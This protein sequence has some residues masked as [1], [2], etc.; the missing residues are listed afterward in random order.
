MKT[1]KILIFLGHP[2]KETL[3]GAMASA[4]ERGAR[5][6]GHEVKRIN[7]GDLVFDPILHKGYKA[8][9]EL[10]PDLKRVQEE[11]RWCDHFVLFYPNWFISMPALLKGMFERMWLPGFAYR[12]KKNGMGWEKLLKGRTACVYITM[13][14]IP[15]MERLLLGDFTNE[16]QY[17]LLGFAGFDTKVHKFGPVEKISPVKADRLFKACERFGAHAH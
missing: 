11:L 10:E 7:L 3:N 6:A 2:D 9:Q 17:G 1:K 8:I 5:A 13:N 16:I 14:S 12:F 15:F 4:Y